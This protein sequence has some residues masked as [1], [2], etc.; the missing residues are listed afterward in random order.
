MSGITGTE[1]KKIIYDR[2][3]CAKAEKLVGLLGLPKRK[4]AVYFKVPTA[5]L[6]QW[7]FDH[8]EFKDAIEIGRMTFGMK[9]AEALHMKATGFSM[10]DTKVF[11]L[12]DGT[13]VERPYMK[14]YPPDTAAAVKYLTT[15]FKEEWASGDGVSI[16]NTE[17][18]FKQVNQLNVAELDDDEK[19]L[20]YSLNVKQLVENADAI[21]VTDD[22]EEHKLK[23]YE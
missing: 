6:E 9:V 5:T 22:Y 17:I 20:L 15:M 4:L 14:Y 11:C 10:P 2:S 1:K 16:N 8:P 13:V 3:F 19:E 23:R 7:C 12:R 18:N 21:E